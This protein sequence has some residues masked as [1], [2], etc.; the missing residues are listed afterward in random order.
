MTV[1][2]ASMPVSAAGVGRVA[3]REGHVAVVARVRE[4]RLDGRD[5]GPHVG[6]CS[7]LLRPVLEAEVRRHGDGEQDAD[8]HE[9]DEELDEREP[10][11]LPRESSP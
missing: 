8:D 3:S 1:T 4:V 9:H 10:G 11:F 6:L 7:T 2:P 5:G